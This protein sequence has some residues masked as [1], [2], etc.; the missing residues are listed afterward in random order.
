MNNIT[1]VKNSAGNGVGW[2][3][4]GFAY[5]RAKPA[6]WVGAYLITFGITLAI[7]LVPILG[8][9]ASSF[10]SVFFTAGM[11]L[12]CQ[13]QAN[14][15]EFKVDYV[16][17]AFDKKY[18]A[19]IFLPLIYIGLLL[20]IIIPVAILMVLLIG[21]SGAE[22][23]RNNIESNPL[24]ALLFGLVILAFTLPLAMGAW[25][26]PALV[27]LRGFKPWEAFKTSFM[28]CLRNIS[29]ALVYGLL[30]LFWAILASIPFLLGWLIL[31]PI[32][33]TTTFAAYQNIFKTE[34]NLV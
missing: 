10:I 28:G 17:Q 22:M 15:E 30:V 11:M 32:L 27:V 19:L 8:S 18:S 14:G 21:F 23:G 29:P 24:L 25:L 9:I 5:F 3:S 34:N 12:G 7:S 1:I 33:V 2:L 13:A 16:F 6:S 4:Q 31:L 20:A 26:A